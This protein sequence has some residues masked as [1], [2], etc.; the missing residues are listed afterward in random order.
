MVA[1][2]GAALALAVAVV[3]VAGCGGGSDGS[4][5]G[6]EPPQAG[7]PRQ[8]L[9]AFQEA[10]R[11]GEGERACA[12]LTAAATRRLAAATGGRCPQGV[13]EDSRLAAPA[14]E[15]RPGRAQPTAAGEAV[16]PV[17]LGAGEGDQVLLTRE[18]GRWRLATLGLADQLG[19]LIRGSGTPEDAEAAARLVRLHYR[20]GLALS[21]VT[22]GGETAVSAEARTEY[23]RLQQAWER[24]LELASPPER[25]LA[26]LVA[27][28][29]RI[30]ALHGPS[31]RTHVII[32]ALD[33][34]KIAFLDLARAAYAAGEPAL[35]D[36]A[37]ARAVE[38]SEPSRRDAMR[39]LIRTARE[40]PGEGV[41][42]EGA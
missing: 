37:G 4:L 23:L 26:Y 11:V 8:A 42:E 15:G 21:G 28:A 38:L 34:T 2:R 12:L 13:L 9:S 36:R 25:G 16:V 1:V 31:V 5:E 35:G 24:Y 22:A 29:Q 17:R 20:R 30:A 32:A 33:P 6:D 3:V 27:D 7:E 41:L 10:V 19:A 40:H 18:A 39:G 14:R